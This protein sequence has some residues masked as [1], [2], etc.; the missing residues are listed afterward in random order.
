MKKFLKAIQDYFSLPLRIERLEKRIIGTRGLIGTDYRNPLGSAFDVFKSQSE[1]DDF[2][3][4]E[5][6]RLQNKLQKLKSKL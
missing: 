2:M 1:H 4:A 3:K 5:V 6:E